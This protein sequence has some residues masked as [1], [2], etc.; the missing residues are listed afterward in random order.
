M[1]DNALPPVTIGIP[2]FNAESTLLDAVRSVYAQTHTDWELIL[3]DDGSTD[4]SL[5]L[6]FSINDPRVKVYSD[7]QNRRLAARL[8]Q[9][10]SLAKYDYIARMDADD[11]I[12]PERIKCQLR[13]LV[14]NPRLDLVS[15]GVCSLSD[16][17]VPLGIR[18]LSE[19][20]KVT[21]SNVLLGTS[22]ILH[23][24]L[25][26][27][28]DW[29]LRNRYREDVRTGQDYNLWVRA[30]SKN[31]L[32]VGFIKK[33][34][35][36]YRED[37]N[38]VSS[39]LMIAYRESL[40][41]IAR[42]AN[43]NFS[44]SDRANAYFVTLAKLIATQSLSWFGALSLLRKRRNGSPLTQNEKEFFISE[45]EYVKSITIPRMVNNTLKRYPKI[46]G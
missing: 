44:N 4:R 9:M 30:Y 18:V 36:Y 46:V 43:Y 12:S 27:N 40:R 45:I 19:E 42:D 3:L 28:R 2:F 34:L 10:P 41:T 25:L 32:N 23:G 6:A 11:L 22:G 8:N 1:V 29:F 20:H 15:T 14:D 38:V 5:E 7:G 33:P 21:S 37:G 31:D 13:L 35:Y 17:N 16:C 24:S 39:K 26:G